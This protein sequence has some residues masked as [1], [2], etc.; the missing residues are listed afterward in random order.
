M[1][2]K[3]KSMYRLKLLFLLLL[4]STTLKSQIYTSEIPFSLEE[5]KPYKGFKTCTQYITD[6]TGGKSK[7]IAFKTWKFNSLGQPLTECLLYDEK[8]G[9]GQINTDTISRTYFEYDTENRLIHYRYGV[10]YDKFK[11]VSSYYTYNQKGLLEKT[12]IVSSE[13]KFYF[14]DTVGM[15]TESKTIGLNKY[16][17]KEVE[18]FKA[19]YKTDLNGRILEKKIVTTVEDTNIDYMTSV[20]TFN[21]KGQLVLYQNYT[22]QSLT[23]EEK[24]TYD[25]KGKVISS[26][27]YKADFSGYEALNY[28]SYKYSK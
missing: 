20:Y 1:P 24:Y 16:D 27:I 3:L 21:D 28:F 11:G 9:F 22:F 4:C 8:E 26:S 19:Q 23:N 6:T 5:S 25:K 7:K 18:L 17:S 13:R 2:L 10:H 14:Y 15:L 12:E